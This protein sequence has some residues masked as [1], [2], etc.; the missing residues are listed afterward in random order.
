MSSATSPADAIGAS[1]PVSRRQRPRPR[2][3][4][5]ARRVLGEILVTLAVLILLFQGWKIWFNDIVYGA[6][7]TS[8][9]VDLSE[10]W[11][12][13]VFNPPP[14]EPLDPA[15]PVVAEQPAD[16]EHFATIMI[17]AL[18][19]DYRKVIAEGVGHNV[20]NN[21]QLGIGHYP[22]TQMPGELGNIVVASHR[23]AYGGA[24]HNVHQLEVGDNVYLETKDGWYKYVYRST[25]YVLATQVEVLAPV[26]QAPGV[27]PTDSILTITTCNPFLSTAERIIVYTVF[28]SWYPRADGPPEEIAALVK[29]AG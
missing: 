5:F 25:S 7:Q 2:G 23:T 4:G 28:D 3:W 16:G 15:T 19:K 29:K 9:A 12:D 26:P 6:S 24:F 27:E 1:A 10:S 14:A 22:S 8:A 17:P 13:P 20:L 18:G 11:S 21:P